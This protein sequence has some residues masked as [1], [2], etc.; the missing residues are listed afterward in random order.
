MSG[1][2]AAAGTASVLA[3]T[4]RRVAHVMGFPVSLAVRGRHAD[5]EPVEP[6]LV[7]PGLV[8]LELD[9]E[10]ATAL[11][12]ATVPALAVASVEVW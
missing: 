7:E 9:A 12:T 2:P 4:V 8:E 5:D 6:E 10:P 1:V 3:G 11:L